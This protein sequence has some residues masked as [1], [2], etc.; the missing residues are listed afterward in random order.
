MT[1]T[2]ANTSPQER[3][4]VTILGSTGSIGTQALDVIRAHPE[5]FEVVGISASSNA[6]LLSEQAREFQPG[7]VAF[8]G[9]GADVLDA[10]NAGVIAGS[11]SAAELARVATDIVLN[12]VVGFA[13]LAATVAT[14]EAGNRLALANKESIVAGGGWVTGLSSG[15]PIIPVDSEH[16][17][18]FQCLE[19]R[20]RDRVAGI[21]LTASGGPF[22]AT[23][24]ADLMNAGPED[25]LKHPTWSM[26][27]KNTLD[28]ATM[29]NKGLEVIEA[30]HLFG[31][32]YEDIKVVV[33]RQAVVHGG[34]TFDDGVAILHASPP[35]MRL[36]IAYGMLYPE[37]VDSPVGETDFAGVSWTFDEPRNDVFRCLP[38]ACEAGRMGGAYPVALNAAN[39]VAIEA[40]IEGRI[41]FLDIAD[42]IEETLEGSSA[43][44]G[45]GKMESLEAIVSVDERARGSAGK[46][47]E[48]RA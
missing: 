14:L 15:N 10:G 6:G 3:R 33:H 12:G 13:G 42:L 8:E 5:R 29:M 43:F 28:S 48:D 39:E 46:I 1:D 38:L 45:A 21:L 44:D 26:G 23:P 18:I 24:K 22:F 4:R 36:P 30:H 17:A 7:Y 32:P 41:K 34:V 19:G 35:D 27:V 9:G 47:L 20:D 37:R 40:F 16:S 31:V 2:S 25:A 11:G